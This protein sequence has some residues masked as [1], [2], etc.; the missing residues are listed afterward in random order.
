MPTRAGPFDVAWVSRE[1]PRE[2]LREV[3]QEVLREVPQEVL[4]EVGTVRLERLVPIVRRPPVA[5]PPTGVLAGGRP[6]RTGPR[7]G[8]A[9]R[10]RT[11]SCER[12][13]SREQKGRGCG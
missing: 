7:E 6:G 1:V 10:E 11:G 8:A 5:D 3:P 13:G 12:T 2:V 9:R 4:R